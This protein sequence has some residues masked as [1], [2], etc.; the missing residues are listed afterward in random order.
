M[1][2]Q[3]NLNQYQFSGLGVLHW[4]GRAWDVFFRCCAFLTNPN[5]IIAIPCDWVSRLVEFCS[6]CLY[7]QSCYMDFSNLF[8]GFVKINTWISLSCYMDLLKNM[9][10]S[11]LF[12]F[13]CQTK[14]NWSLAKISKFFE[15]FSLNRRCWMS[16][17]TQ[18]LGS[19][20][21]L[22]IFFWG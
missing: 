7:C 5:S 17:G 20:V 13:S 2:N 9:D 14:P 11:K 6:N 15:A 10:L 12:Y 1:N 16:Q 4:A 19:V 21:P 3:F 22:A 18:C 8:N